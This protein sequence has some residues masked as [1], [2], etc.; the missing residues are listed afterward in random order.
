MLVSTTDSIIATTNTSDLKVY[1]PVFENQ[2]A[3]TV[4]KN[5][6]NRQVELFNETVNEMDITENYTNELHIAYHIDQCQDHLVSVV[7]DQYWF[8]GGAHGNTV[9]SKAVMDVKHQK[10]YVLND[11]FTGDPL[12]SIQ[13]PVRQILKKLIDFH[14]FINDGTASTNDFEIFSINDSLITFYFTPYQVAPYAYGSQKVSLPLTSLTNFK[15]PE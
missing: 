2:Y 6:V 1:Y 11:F 5:M 7:F 4:V 8:I 9:F 14:E 3:D 13:E 12:T 15:L 10:K